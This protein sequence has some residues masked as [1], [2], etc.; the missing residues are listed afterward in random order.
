MNMTTI[1]LDF[2]TVSLQLHR[3]VRCSERMQGCSGSDSGGGMRCSGGVTGAMGCVFQVSTGNTEIEGR[4]DVY[5]L[6]LIPVHPL[7]LIFP[8]SLWHNRY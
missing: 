8:I 2:L 6:H 4:T 5:P 1:A 7:H 3:V